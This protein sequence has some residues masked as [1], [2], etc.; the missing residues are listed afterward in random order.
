MV[1]MFLMM[2]PWYIP[3]IDMAKKLVFKYPSP[4]FSATSGIWCS[5]TNTT[6][7]AADR[8]MESKP[9]LVYLLKLNEILK[10]TY[11]AFM[12]VI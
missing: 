9:D 5:S 7:H 12:V 6:S 8:K 11:Y 1:R 2:H 3:S 10:R 4:L